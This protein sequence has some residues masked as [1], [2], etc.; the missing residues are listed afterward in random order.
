MEQY[1]GKIV[2]LNRKQEKL[3]QEYIC[4]KTGIARSQLSRYER[5]KEKISTDNIKNIFQVMNIEVY[6]HDENTFEKDF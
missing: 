3:K 1:I 2:R 4:V 6:P 5:N